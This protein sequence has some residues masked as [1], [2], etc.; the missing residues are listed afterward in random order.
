MDPGYV[1]KRK[2]NIMQMINFWKNKSLG[3]GVGDKGGSFNLD[4]Y[5]KYLNVT[6]ESFERIDT[7][8]FNIT[9]IPEH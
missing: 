4:L 7:F 8:D 6:N 5:L 2:P 3:N 9:G 1:V